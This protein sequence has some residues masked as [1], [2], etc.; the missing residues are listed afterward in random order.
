MVSVVRGEN[1]DAPSLLKHFYT[2]PPKDQS[3]PR[4]A[5]HSPIIP[6]P[7]DLRFDLKNN[8]LF[9]VKYMGIG[10][11]GQGEMQLNNF[12]ASHIQGRTP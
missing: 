7:N 2:Q 11:A 6:M 9:E 1:R 3:E 5:E 8:T 4:N 10:V 12:L